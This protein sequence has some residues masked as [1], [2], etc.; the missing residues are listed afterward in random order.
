MADFEDANS[1]TWENVH[2]GAAQP[3][4]T[5]STGRSHSST[6]EKHYELTTRS[7]PVVR[8]RGWHLEE[9][10]SRSTA[11]RCPASCSTSASTSSATKSCANAARAV[12]LPA[13]ARVTPRGAALERRLLLAQDRLGVAR[14]TIRA[15]VLI[16]T[17]LA[18]FEMDEILYELREH[19]AGLNAGRWDYIFSVDQEVRAP[20]RVRAARPLARDDGG[21]VHARVHRAARPR[22]ATVAA[23]T[24]SA[25]WRRSSL[26][27]RPGG[28]RDRAREGARGQGARGLAGLRRHLGRP[29]RP[30]AGREGD[31]RPRAGRPAEPDRALREDVARHGG[32]PARRRS[33]PG[34]ITRGG[35]AQ[36][37]RGRHPV[38]RG[39]AARV[40]RGRRSTT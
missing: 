39:L 28:E 12:L 31:L 32:R 19:S 14:G 2:R 20:A 23:R 38:P 4:R 10:H 21:A 8:P 36:Q 22:P 25:G 18:A 9:R 40:R 11:P 5:R 16:E 3:A 27:P 24:R 34:E 30:R 6:G 33:T 1:P 17:I 15:T 13:Q 35:S 29:P 7:R 37:R 26:A